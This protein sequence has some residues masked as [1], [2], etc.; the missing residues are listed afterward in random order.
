MSIKNL[1]SPVVVLLA[2]ACGN[3]EKVSKEVFEEVNRNMEVKRLTEAEIIE[4]AME[5][6]DSITTEAQEQL[7]SNL[8]NSISANGITG[9]IDFCQVN[10]LPF[11]TQ[12]G[13]DFGV[14]IKRVSNRYRNPVDQPNESELPILEA[15]EYNADNG[16]KSEPN[17]QK[18]EGGEVFLYTK[19]I[20]IPS[21]FCLACH[22]EVGKDIDP[23]TQ[24][25]LLEKYPEDKAT[26]H[27]IGD[28]RGMWSVLIPKGEVV[29]RL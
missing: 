20:T 28:L 15:Y 2:F 21:G 8:Q 17:V 13:D 24:A 7:I 10:A 5:W 12:V 23:N 9:A 27:Q 22:G 4:E 18:I 3:G 14:K 25:K 19:P 26:G 16:Q 11:L 6:G 29:K 1:V